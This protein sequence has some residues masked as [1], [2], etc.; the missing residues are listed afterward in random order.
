MCDFQQ[1]STYGLKGD[2]FQ[3]DYRLYEL[4]NIYRKYF[5]IYFLLQCRNLKR[6][7]VLLNIHDNSFFLFHIIKYFISCKYGSILFNCLKYTKFHD[8]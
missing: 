3:Y 6:I 4:Y 1:V 2:C 8:I 5:N 7:L